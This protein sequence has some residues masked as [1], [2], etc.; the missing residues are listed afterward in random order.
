MVTRWSSHKKVT[1]SF[2]GFVFFLIGYFYYFSEV[3]CNVFLSYSLPLFP[4]T[5]LILLPP[6]STLCPV[7]SSFRSHC[8]EADTLVLQH[9]QP[10]WPPPQLQSWVVDALSGAGHSSLTLR[11]LT[12]LSLSAVERAS[13]RG[14][15]L[16]LSVAV[17]VSIEWFR[18]A[19]AVGFCEVPWAHQSWVVMCL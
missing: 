11:V 6:P 14:W 5:P 16:Q 13:W 4:P 10:F 1:T 7:S 3:A 12:V 18:K 8:L 2:T 19:A 15:E 9:L 17:T